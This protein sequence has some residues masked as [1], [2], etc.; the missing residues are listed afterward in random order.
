L[1][2]CDALIQIVDASG[3]TD[4]EGNPIGTGGSTP[5]EEYHFLLKELDAWI[6]GIISSGWHRGARRVQSEGEKA[7]SLYL[8]DQLSGIG[9]KEIHITS[10]VAAVHEKFPNAGV[11][12]GWGKEELTTIASTIRSELFPISVAANKADSASKESW[13]EIQEVVKTN[14]GIVVPTSAEA[15]L[16]LRRASRSG[17]ID[18]VPGESDFEITKIGE[19]KLSNPQRKGLISIGN[20]LNSWEGRGLIGLL[21]EVV[22]G[23]LDR[24]VAYPVQDESHWIDG[25][26][27]ILPDA[28]LVPEGTTAKGLAYAVHSDLGDGF[29]RA[30]DARTSRVIGADYEIRNGDII[31]IHA[32]N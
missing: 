10:G 6:T 13:L 4:I 28:I 16:A 27:N 2:R 18:H 12:W 24:K 14:G 7:I 32:K 19:E 9:A 17:L 1:A 25:E 11:P 29:I 20:T 22:F 30:V 3:S 31:R 26:G 5:L 23:I 8:L 15:E 21:S